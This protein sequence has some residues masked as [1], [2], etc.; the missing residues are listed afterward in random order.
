[1]A[2]IRLLNLVS[3]SERRSLVFTGTNLGDIVGQAGANGF[4]NFDFGHAAISLAGLVRLTHG[5]ILF[6]LSSGCAHPEMANFPD[7]SVARKI[8]SSAYQPYA[9]GKIFHA[10]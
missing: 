3:L 7:I 10:P 6:V 4:F 1:V 2:N 5:G 8:L 9:C